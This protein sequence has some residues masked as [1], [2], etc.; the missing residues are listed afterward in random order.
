MRHYDR[1]DA[2]RTAL[3]SEIG[4]DVRRESAGIANAGEIV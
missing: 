3:A 2:G 4:S 1:R